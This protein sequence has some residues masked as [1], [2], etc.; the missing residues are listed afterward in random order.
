MSDF[1]SFNNLL[2]AEGAHVGGFVSF[3]D[4]VVW[5]GLLDTLKLV[6]F[7]FLTYLLMEYIEHKAEEKTESIIKKAGAFGPLLGGA[8]GAVPQCG[9]STVAANLYTGRVISVG[10]LIAVFLST[11]DEMLPIMIAGNVKIGTVLLIIIYKCLVGVLVGTSIDL[12]LKLRKRN[13]EDINIDEICD[14]DNCHC[15]KGIL[16]SAI[17]H[18]LTTSLFVLFVTIA[19]NTVVFFLGD[20]FFA[21]M[22]DIPFVSHLLCALVGLIPNCAASVA[23]TKLAMAGV[24]SSG[25]MM[26]GLFSGAGAGLLVLFKVN[27]HRKENLTVAA[28]LVVVG[29]VFGLLADLIPFLSI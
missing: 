24:I 3:L 20:G 27:K 12:I 6:G 17:H 11:S 29:L 15:E 25:A 23:L 14:N 4:E 21:G 9:F 26:S 7:L 10:T 19:I 2:H 13:T 18:T 16:H 8:L 1:V 28:A 5:H 22:T